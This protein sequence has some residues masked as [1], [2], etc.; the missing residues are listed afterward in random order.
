MK[1]VEINSALIHC[2]NT[3]PLHENVIYVEGNEDNIEIYLG[4]Q[5]MFAFKNFIIDA[6][7]AKPHTNTILCYGDSITHGYCSQY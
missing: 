2:K 6:E 1:M 5:N 7:S 4:Y 3:K